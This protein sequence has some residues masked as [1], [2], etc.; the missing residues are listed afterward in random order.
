M[1]KPLQRCGSCSIFEGA[2]GGSNLKISCSLQQGG[3]LL[4]DM[5]VEQEK[6]G[7]K[8]YQTIVKIHPDKKA[9][10][11]SGNAEA[12]YLKEP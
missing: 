12:G 10:I 2:C 7:Y 5:I 4:L 6:S 11:A 1:V 9:I 8:I 3:S